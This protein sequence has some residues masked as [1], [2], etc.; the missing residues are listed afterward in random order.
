MRSKPSTA[1][2]HD[3]HACSSR[4]TVAG[5]ALSLIT[6][7]WKR[8]LAPTRA[9]ES[10]IA[11]RPANTRSTGSWQIGITIAVGVSGR[12]VSGSGMPWWVIAKRS[13]RTRQ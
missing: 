9:S 4:T 10:S 12:A 6:K 5:S 3:N 7:K 8:A 1:R 13:P 11:R 2:H